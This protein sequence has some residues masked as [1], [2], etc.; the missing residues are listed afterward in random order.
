[1]FER[2]IYNDIVLWYESFVY[3]IFNQIM[4]NKMCIIK[5]NKY[6]LYNIL[7][8]HIFQSIIYENK[9]LIVH[10][11]NYIFEKIKEKWYINN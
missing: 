1:M 9:L 11:F 2:K 5:N 3:G 8:L 6:N 7:L 10:I 4:N